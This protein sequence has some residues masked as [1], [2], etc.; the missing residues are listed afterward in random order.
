[1][2]RQDS[3][4]EEVVELADR[5]HSAAI[6][7]L[8]S[9]R[10]LDEETGLSGPRLSLLSV[11]VFRGPATIGELAEAEQV[12]PPTISRMVKDMEREGL[13]TRRT[14][15]SDRRVH[16]IRAT[17][18]GRSVLQAGRRRRVASLADGLSTLTGEER[19]VLTEAARILGS[20]GSRGHP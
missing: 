5:L 10:H 6:R 19:R 17:P 14:D 1:M 2:S 20:L 8:R 12:T 9:V 4:T 16:R 7:L 11:L 13:V 3:R 18:A 15:P